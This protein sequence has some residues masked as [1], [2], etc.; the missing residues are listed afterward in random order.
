MSFLLVSLIISTYNLGSLFT[1]LP[2]S[3]DFQYRYATTFKVY[4]SSPEHTKHTSYLMNNS[5]PL[6]NG[7]YF[8]DNLEIDSSWKGAS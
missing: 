5:N 3:C 4:I 7:P 1:Q 8:T 2:Q 6:P